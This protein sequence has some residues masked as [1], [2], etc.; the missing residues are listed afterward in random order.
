MR[1]YILANAGPPIQVSG[2]FNFNEASYI[3]TFAFATYTYFMCDFYLDPNI[4]VSRY[5]ISGGSVDDGIQVM[6]NG[7]ILGRR[8]LGEGAFSWP[9][10]SANSGAINTLI[11]ILVDDSASNKYAWDLAFTLDGQMVE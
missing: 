2:P 9:L 6:M 10:Q 4:D 5:A 8:L 1:Q 11:I 3:S 7:E